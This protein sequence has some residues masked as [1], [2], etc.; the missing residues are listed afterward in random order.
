MNIESRIHLY[1]NKF[2]LKS[3]DQLFYNGLENLFQHARDLI[4]DDELY[5]REIIQTIKNY[6]WLSIFIWLF[7]QIQSEYNECKL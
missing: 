7:L 4:D 5:F 1:E 6:G 2:G 3:N